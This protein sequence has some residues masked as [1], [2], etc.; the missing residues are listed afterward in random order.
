MKKIIFILVSLLILI[1]ILI[2]LKIPKEYAYTKAICNQ[3]NYCE[4]YFVT[5]SGNEVKSLT[6]TGFAI[7][8]GKNWIDERKNTKLCD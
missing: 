5:C 1:F 7:Q 6:A 2:T 8:Q 4:D 3:E